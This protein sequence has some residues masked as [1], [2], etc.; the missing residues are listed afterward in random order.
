M[1]H[2]WPKLTN[3]YRKKRVDVSG[4]DIS[5][6]SICDNYVNMQPLLF[7]CVRACARAC[8]CVCLFGGGGGEGVFSIGATY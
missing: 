2:A 1:S 3:A 6:S 7:M 5:I 4:L 8:V